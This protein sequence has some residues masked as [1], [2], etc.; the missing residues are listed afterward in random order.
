[1]RDT[2]KG[3]LAKYIF[4][5]YVC[6]VTRQTNVQSLSRFMLKFTLFMQLIIKWWRTQPH[7]AVIKNQLP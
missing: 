7:G 4:K 6:L 5:T 2:Y 1:M 3:R